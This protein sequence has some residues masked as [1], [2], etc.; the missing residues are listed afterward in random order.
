MEREANFN[1][2][3]IVESDAAFGGLVIESEA[4][5]GGLEIMESFADFGGLEM[6]SEAEFL[7]TVDVE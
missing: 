2:L 4:V 1:G 5:T 7:G 6:E 3:D